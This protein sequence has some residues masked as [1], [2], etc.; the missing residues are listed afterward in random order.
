[1]FLC[2]KCVCGYVSVD[3]VVVCVFV[4]WFKCIFERCL[5]FVVLDVCFGGADCFCVGVGFGF[6]LLFVL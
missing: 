2:W 4:F 6:F 3:V 5:A 1:M